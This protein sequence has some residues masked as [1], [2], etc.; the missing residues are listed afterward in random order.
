MEKYGITAIDLEKDIGIEENIPICNVKLQLKNKD[1]AP[2]IFKLQNEEAN[3]HQTIISIK[4]QKTL[5]INLHQAAQ[6]NDE[7]L[8]QEILRFFNSIE[9]RTA[10]IDKEEKIQS[11]TFQGNNFVIN[12]TIEI[13]V[14]HDDGEGNLDIEIIKGADKQAAKM[15]ANDLMDGLYLGSIKEAI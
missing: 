10:Q 13:H 12:K 1:E 7:A 4:Q 5:D 8:N 6:D 15:R 9:T 3:F 2:V 14:L 11:I